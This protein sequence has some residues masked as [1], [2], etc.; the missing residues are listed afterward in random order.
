LTTV[1]DAV[2]ACA[3]SAALIVACRLLLESTV[4]VR[5]E[6]FQLRNAPEAKFVPVTVMVNPDPPG[7][8]E[9][10]LSG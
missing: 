9:T 4:V 6:P 5:D 2:V 7:A 3:M 8:A 10:G 1:I